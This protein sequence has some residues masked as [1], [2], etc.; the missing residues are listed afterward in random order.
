MPET[1]SL[2]AKIAELDAELTK[3]RR[4]RGKW[5]ARCSKLEADLAAVHRAA[6]ILGINPEEHGDRAKALPGGVSGVV[7]EAAYSLV[8]AITV[9]AVKEAREELAG[10]PNSS[11]SRVLIRMRRD[12]DLELARKGK[13]KRPSLYRVPD[14][15]QTDQDASESDEGDAAEEG[16]VTPFR[17]VEGGSG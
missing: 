15:K 1:D 12:G 8:E 10:V 3:A 16:S 5:A 6:E 9:N 7:R 17:R 2:I 13:G 14:A 11:I 4:Y